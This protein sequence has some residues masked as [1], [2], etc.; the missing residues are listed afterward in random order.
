[1]SGRRRLFEHPALWLYALAA[2]LIGSA[3][4]ASV[5]WLV[6]LPPRV[7][8]MS[9]GAPGSDYDRLAPR[10][11]AILR[12][13]G[14]TLRLLPSAGAVE[15]LRRL[16]DPKSGVSVG[17]A[18]GG[19][20]T[21]AQS[22]ELRSLGTM[23]F[24]PFWFFTRVSPG[25]RFEGL[26]GKVL[27]IGQPGAGTRALAARLLALNGIDQNIAELRSLTPS[28]AGDA[29][30]H[31]EI[32]AMALVASW[33]SPVVR[34]LLAS[35]EVNLV[36]FPRADAYV[37]LYPE[38][39]KL[40]LPAGV[41]NIATNRPPT[42]V[43]LIAPKASLI[44][45]HDLHPAIQYL[46]LEA[47]TEIQSAPT[48]FHQ[49]GEFPAA[50]RGDV[51]LSQ[52][53]RQ[54]YKSGTPFLQRYLPFWLAVL[55]S[56]L[57]LL[58]IPVMGIAYPLVR[59]APGLYRWNFQRR[60]FRLYGELK[61]IEAELARPGGALDGDAIGRLQRLDERANRMLVPVSYA[62]LLYTLRMHIALVRDQVARNAN[63]RTAT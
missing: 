21:D 58:L 12:R 44:V 28:R 13:S 55:A 10:Y 31:G 42:D 62:Q 63:S 3:A 30:L 43:N 26:R 49:A 56:Q 6:S 2:A 52:T 47:A 40:I 14:V 57:L 7:V 25:P 45:R 33:D 41:G 48:I 20:T 35:S 54:F 51:P 24:E 53:A 29:L 9:T 8:V 50:E 36:G 46:L 4:V 39:S 38:L 60:I 17:F 18:Q 23:F 27:S 16:N 15:N 22:P 61:F 34:Q 5:L 37:A 59:F 1:M 19:L 11:Q 32:D